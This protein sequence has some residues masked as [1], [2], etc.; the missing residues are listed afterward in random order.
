MSCPLCRHQQTQFY[1]QDKRREYLQCQHC[2][3]VFVPEKYWLDS[4]QEKAEYD[5]H[6]NHSADEGYRKFLSRLVEP[7]QAELRAGSRGLD[8]GC[9]PGPTLSVMMAER[10]WSMALYDIYYFPDDE[11]LNQN[12]DFITATEVVEHLC[13]PGKVLENIWHLIN[14]EGS[15]ALMTKMLIDKEAFAHW[16]YKNDPTH[17]CFFSKSSFEYLANRWQ[18]ELTIIGK[19]VILLKKVKD[20]AVV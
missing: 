10:G 8:F 5:K 18:A 14:H 19:D 13:E 15:L 2:E 4:E 20:S 9:G 7:L 3:L 12:Y 1:Y 11:V 6:Q 16:H 17:I